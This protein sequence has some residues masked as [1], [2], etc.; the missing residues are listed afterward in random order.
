[1]FMNAKF[2]KSAN[3]LLSLKALDEER[4]AR[5]ISA[6]RSDPYRPMPIVFKVRESGGKVSWPQKFR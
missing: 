4:R 6:Y 5:E 3:A 1:M 2:H